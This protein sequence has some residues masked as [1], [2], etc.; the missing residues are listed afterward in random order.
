[1]QG[2]VSKAA[3]REVVKGRG[4]PLHVKAREEGVLEEGKGASEKLGAVDKKK[5]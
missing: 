4:K 2:R 1:V 5:E 3:M